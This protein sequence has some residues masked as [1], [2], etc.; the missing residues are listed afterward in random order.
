MRK[1]FTRKLEPLRIL[2]NIQVEYIH[3]STLEVLEKTG[4]KFESDRALKL[5]KE[6]GCR[7]DFETKVAKFPAFPC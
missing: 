7:V 5:L 3:S 4:V 1:G 6:S 2:S